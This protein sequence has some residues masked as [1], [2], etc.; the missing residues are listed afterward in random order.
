MST[1][2]GYSLVILLYSISSEF[3][4][5]PSRVYVVDYPLSLASFLSLSQ[6]PDPL[7]SV[8]SFSLLLKLAEGA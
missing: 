5:S 1:T 7:C 3:S 2:M 6:R 4:E 8:I